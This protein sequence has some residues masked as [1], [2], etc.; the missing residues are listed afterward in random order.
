MFK[1]KHT[2]NKVMY[3]LMDENI[4]TRGSQEPNPVSPI[5]ANDLVFANLVFIVTLWNITTI[6]NE[7]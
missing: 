7:N 1:Q 5:G 4:V 2:Q 3:Q 6:S